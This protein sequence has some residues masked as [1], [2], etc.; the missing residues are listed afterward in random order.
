LLPAGSL[1]WRWAAPSTDDAVACLQLELGLL[2]DFCAR[3][4]DDAEVG[5]AREFLRRSYAFEVDTGKKRLQQKLDRALLAVPDDVHA[6][7]LERM[8]TVTA[9]EASSA[10]AKRIDPNAL[11]VAAVVDAA[12]GGEALRDALAWDDVVV[13]P[14]DRD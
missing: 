8:G 10:V 5:F 1:T 11:T 9:T 7:M 12:E 6:T 3:G 4:L 14:Y 2:E 13:E